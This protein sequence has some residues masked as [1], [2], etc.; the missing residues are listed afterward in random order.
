MKTWLRWGGSLVLVTLLATR[1]DWS[2]VGEAFARLRLDLWL[3]A[4]LLFG[5]C[6]V[7]SAL[8]W[9]MLAR[10]LG[11]QV[12][13][14]RYTGVYFIGMLFNLILP[15]SVGGDVVRAWYL[16]GMPCRSQMGRTT[17]ATFSVLVERVSGLMMLVAIACVALWCSPLELPSWVNGAVLLA[18]LAMLAGLA[19]LF[20]GG[21]FARWILPALPARLQ[22][23]V[24]RVFT[25]TRLYLR[26][27]WTLLITSLLSVVVQGLNVIVV[28]CVGL[29]LGLDVPLICY[30]VVVPL[31]ALL[32]LVPIS[33][34]GMGLREAGYAILMRPLGVPTHTAV[35]LAFLSFLV[36]VV[37]SLAG[38][39]FY[40][41]GQYPR[42]RPTASEETN[43][44]RAIRGDSDQGRGGQSAAAA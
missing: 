12:S 5:I 2:R 31:T 17:L 25:A 11:F 14:A 37:C 41:F 23:L 21:W 30:G 19:F 18:G 4:V 33:L 29:G 28:W 8:R 39:G 26:H 43:D 35:A 24:V 42:Y 15:T 36:T 6:Q 34:N 13:Q 7:V 38:L 3:L 44:D 10:V 22:A 40:L 9:G 1:L 32:T 27:P 20:V 16:A